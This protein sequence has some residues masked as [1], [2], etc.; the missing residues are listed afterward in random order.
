MIRLQWFFK[1]KTN[2]IE[3]KNNLQMEHF[4]EIKVPS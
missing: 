1:V 2:K 4:A 3:L